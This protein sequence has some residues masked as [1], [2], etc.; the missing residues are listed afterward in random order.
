MADR[1]PLVGVEFGIVLA[2]GR[3]FGPR[4]NQDV[5]LI[6][7]TGASTTTLQAALLTE[8]GIDLS[9]SKEQRRVNT[10]GG[11]VT[12][13]VIEVPRLRIFGKEQAPLE[14]IFTERPFPYQVDG[15][16]GLNF[17]LPYRLCLDFPAGWIEL[18]KST[19]IPD[20]SAG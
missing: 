1:Y 11:P 17:L 5:V 6:L 9:A 4:D 19:P 16:L 14:V 12:E 13:G 3:V 7:D 10:M 8:V 15:V 20:S 18:R 2:A